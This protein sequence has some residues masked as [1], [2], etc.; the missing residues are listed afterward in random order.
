MRRRDLLIGACALP[1]LFTAQNVFARSVVHRLC[2]YPGT[3]K[4]KIPYSD[5]MSGFRPFA[6]NFGDNLHL[7]VRLLRS[8]DKLYETLA[9]DNP[10]FV[11]FWSTSISSFFYGS[12]AYSFSPCFKKGSRYD[13]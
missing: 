4:A 10:P 1:V 6:N 9:S 12:G 7:N 11:C 3:G 5:F 2:V 8:I 13:C